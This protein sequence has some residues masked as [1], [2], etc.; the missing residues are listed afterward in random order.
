MKRDILQSK[1]LRKLEFS[2]DQ[3]QDLDLALG[4]VLCPYP[5]EEGH[6][7][8]SINEELLGMLNI[9]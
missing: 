7:L 9:I 8:S 1:I 4:P 3:L 2:T 6:R 5:E